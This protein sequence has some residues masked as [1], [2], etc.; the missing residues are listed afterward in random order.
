MSSW[1]W[2]CSLSTTESP[3]P[4]SSTGLGLRAS[5]S[6]STSLIL[7]LED[8][9]ARL[10]A[11]GASREGLAFS[12][13][14]D[15]AH[16]RDHV[17]VRPPPQE[18]PGAL[19]GQSL[20]SR[21][22]SGQRLAAA[23]RFS[24]ISSSARCRV[25]P[26]RRPSRRS[27]SL[28]GPAPPA[29]PLRRRAAA[30]VASLLHADH[31]EAEGASRT[32]S[33][34]SSPAPG[35]R[36]P[37]R[38]PGVM[39]PRTKKPRSPPVDLGSPDP[40]CGSAG[41]LPRSPRCPPAAAAG[42]PPGPSPGRR[43]RSASDRHRCRGSDQHVARPHLLRAGRIRSRFSGVIE[44]PD[45]GLRVARPGA[46]STRP[47][48]T[49]ICPVSSRGIQLDEGDLADL[50]AP[51]DHAANLA[52]RP[53]RDGDARRRSRS[54]TLSDQ[55]AGRAGPRWKRLQAAELAADRAKP[56]APGR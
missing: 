2:V 21:A 27:S 38:R 3:R 53:R 25:Q 13:S 6:T 44:G 20:A 52:P 30:G 34:I 35:R 54:R 45:L 37:L 40:G 56:P 17:P 32:T 11:S 23:D 24:A 14:G 4:Q 46:R 9:G 1:S 19:Q 26:G 51:Q 50:F 8:P 43:S 15:G 29:S 41:H 55:D 22:A 28:V 39:S 7:H 31:V 36:R 33:L 47:S 12:T 48:S 18:D 42:W 49:W 16:A 10:V 5:S